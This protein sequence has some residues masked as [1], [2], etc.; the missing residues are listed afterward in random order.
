MTRE[1]KFRAKALSG[2]WVVG[3]FIHSKRF[4]GCSNE[5]R[6]HDVE[7]GMEHDIIIETLCQYTGL[8]DKNG[9][10]IY[11]GDIL[12]DWF[13]VDGEKRQSFMQ[14]FWCKKTGAWRLDNSFIQDRSSGDLLSEE[15]SDF[16]YEV[17]GNLYDTPELIRN[18]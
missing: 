9:K 16:A 11:E 18:F 8:K 14:V 7:T 13:D 10:E 3:N 4:D 12:S 1:L 17:T 15:L 2:E 6:I 5:F